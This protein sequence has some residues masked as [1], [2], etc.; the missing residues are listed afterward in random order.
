[1]AQ[2]FIQHVTVF[3]KLSA[4]IEEFVDMTEDGDENNSDEGTEE[5]MNE[6]DDQIPFEL[7]ESLCFL[8]TETETKKAADKS[9]K[10]FTAALVIYDTP[11]ELEV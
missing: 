5:K 7:G 9:L 11:P 10:I 8:D 3:S 2:L 6:S 1:M 4:D